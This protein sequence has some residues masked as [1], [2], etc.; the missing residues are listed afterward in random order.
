[1]KDGQ[2]YVVGANALFQDNL[3]IHTEIRE[4]TKKAGSQYPA[5]QMAEGWI[6]GMVIEAALKATEE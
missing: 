5:E 3:P 6:A 2:F 4:A 1:M